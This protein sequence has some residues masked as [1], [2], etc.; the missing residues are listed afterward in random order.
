MDPQVMAAAGELE[1]LGEDIMALEAHR[2]ELDKGRQSTRMAHREL[3][4]KSAAGDT[5]M[6][7]DVGLFVSM[8]NAAAKKDLAQEQERIDRLIYE[9]QEDVKE[10]TL[11]LA[12]LENNDNLLHMAA[13]YQLKGMSSKEASFNPNE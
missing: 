12:H 9:N 3:S 4:K 6:M 5:W 2:V 7:T 10:K 1:T 8:P 13:Q 11:K